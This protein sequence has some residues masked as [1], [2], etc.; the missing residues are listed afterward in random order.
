MTT[1][2]PPHHHQRSTIWGPSLKAPLVHVTLGG[3][4]CNTHRGLAAIE[5]FLHC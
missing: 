1:Y 3:K 2:Y 4:F 5:S